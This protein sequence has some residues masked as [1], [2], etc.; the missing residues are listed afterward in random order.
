MSKL[1]VSKITKGTNIRWEQ[2]YEI[3]GYHWALVSDESN[4][5]GG[6]INAYTVLFSD[7]ETDM[8]GV[9]IGEQPDLLLYA[10][11]HNVT[12]E[13]GMGPR[14]MKEKLEEAVRLLMDARDKVWNA[15]LDEARRWGSELEQA[16][17]HANKHTKEFDDFLSTLTK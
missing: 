1:D 13:T 12:N 14:E 11:A 10:E 9:S 2:C 4:K 16:K 15:R 5:A 17:V 3:N 7:D 6:V 8:S